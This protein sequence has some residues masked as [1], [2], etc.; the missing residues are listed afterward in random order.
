MLTL[1]G[2]S[3][4]QAPLLLV[5]LQVPSLPSLK[6]NDIGTLASLVI[7]AQLDKKRIENN[8]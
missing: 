7:L 1:V 6:D 8:K 4:V 3:A 2:M 5:K